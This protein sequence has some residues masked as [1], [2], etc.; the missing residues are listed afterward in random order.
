MSLIAAAAAANPTPPRDL[1]CCRTAPLYLQAGTWGAGPADAARSPRPAAPSATPVEDG[2]TVAPCHLPGCASPCPQTAQPGQWVFA[3]G[4]TR[5][6]DRLGVSSRR[7]PACARVVRACQVHGAGW[8]QAGSVCVVPCAVLRAHSSPQE[9]ISTAPMPVP[10]GVWEQWCWPSELLWGRDTG[11]LPAGPGEQGPQGLPGMGRRGAGPPVYTV[12]PRILAGSSLQGW[13]L[14][15]HS[16]RLQW[17]WWRGA[18]PGGERGV[19]PG[20]SFSRCGGSCG[21]RPWPWVLPCLGSRMRGTMVSVDRKSLC[22]P[23]ELP[24]RSFL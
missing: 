13:V 20:T 4:A 24:G 21:A 10:R 7:A 17:L 14:V 23:R 8:E 6:G 15:P 11:G 2:A 1:A 22:P 9:C 12:A 18:G 19:C 3:F 5:D 16:A